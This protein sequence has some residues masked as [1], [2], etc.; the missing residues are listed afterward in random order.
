MKLKDV[1]A[2]DWQR[3]GVVE[4][5]MGTLYAPKN[6]VVNSV[7]VYIYMYILCPVDFVFCQMSV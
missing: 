2:K 5:E 7:C 1:S 4:W 6:P 3:D